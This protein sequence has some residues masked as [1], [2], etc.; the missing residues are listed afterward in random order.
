MASTGDDM[1][2]HWLEQAGR[3]PLLTAAEELHLGSLVRQWQDHSKGLTE[4]PKKPDPEHRAAIRRGLRARDRMVRANLRL[5][6][7]VT[8][9]RR[10]LLGVYIPDADLPD[11]LQAGAIGLQRGVEKFDPTRGYKVSTFCYW[12]VRQ[13]LSRDVDWNGRTIRIAAGRTDLLCR[14]KVLTR[15]LT[16]ELRRAPTRAE[17]ALVLG[18]SIEDLDHLLLIAAGC[19][20]LDAPPPGGCEDGGL[21]GDALAAPAPDPDFDAEELEARLLCLDP[22]GI[23]L[24]LVTAR[25]GLDGEPRLLRQLAEQEAISE[26]EVR[27]VLASAMAKM[28]G[29]AVP[30]AKPR[31][32]PKPKP[33]PPSSPP[34][35]P[36]PPPPLLEPC[37]PVEGCQLTL[38]LSILNP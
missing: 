15:T 22:D 7:H 30:V 2:S 17:L 11:L 20:S 21:L 27:K 14:A 33:P 35:P 16:R 19:Y 13:A 34:P 9:L 26:G 5:V 3:I 1:I 25:W 28:R 31:R 36:P 38:G 12:W 32:K 8:R 18:V 37:R 10:Q 29:E 4:D 23:E 24:R 6:A